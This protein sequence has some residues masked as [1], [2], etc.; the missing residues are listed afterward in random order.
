MRLIKFILLLI[1]GALLFLGVFGGVLDLA[2]LFSINLSGSTLLI[3][4]LIALGV[5]LLL[6]NSEL[7]WQ[8]SRRRDMQERID[9]L[10]RFRQAA[11]TTLYATTPSVD[12]FPTWLARYQSWEK[13]LIEFLEKAF[14]FAVFEMFND[15]GMIPAE[16]FSQ[17]S[18]E[19]AIAAQHVHHLRMLAKHLKIMERLIEENTSLLPEAK[20]GLG[21]LLKWLPGD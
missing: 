4:S 16:Q 10:A 21:E 20:P 19:P 8:L 3:I 18:K 15:L 9:Q 12:E 1:F 11:V 6:V 5:Y 2:Q 13:S 7:R 17:A 14:P